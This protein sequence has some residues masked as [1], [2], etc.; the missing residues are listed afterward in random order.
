[1]SVSWG[2]G[3]DRLAAGCSCGKVFVFDAN[4]R[5]L[6]QKDLGGSVYSVSWSPDGARLAAGCS[7][8]KVFVFDANGRQLW[9]SEDLGDEVN[10][11]SWSP[12][13]DRLA[14]GT[15]RRVFVFDSRGFGVLGCAGLCGGFLDCLG[16]AGFIGLG[17]GV[18][19]GFDLLSRVY[20]GGVFRVDDV[21]RVLA[22]LVGE[23]FVFDWFY[24]VFAGKDS[25]DDSLISRV[26]RSARSISEGLDRIRD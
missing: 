12:G 7:C 17:L 11:V 19:V 16:L 4:G 20:G 8:G 3:G 21:A 5:Q 2:P 1:M 10:S 24:D 25:V 23:D 6:W 14:A 22:G 26:Y 9:S 15:R 18:P 13:G